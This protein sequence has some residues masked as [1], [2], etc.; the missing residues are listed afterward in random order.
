MGL[1]S[2]AIA[3][4]KASRAE[5]QKSHTQ[6][7]SH[8]PSPGHPAPRSR[9]PSPGPPAASSDNYGSAPPQYST[10]DPSSA[11]YGLVETTDEAYARHLIDKGEAIPWDQPHE[12]EYGD[13]EDEDDDEAYWELDEAAAREEAPGYE[14]SD[15]P[16]YEAK[17]GGS[18]AKE[19]KIDVHKLVKKFLSAHPAPSRAPPLHPLSCHVIIPQR[20]PHSKSRGFVRA[21]AP[22]L[23]DA[24][25]DQATFMDFLETFQK[26]SQVRHMNVP[27]SDIP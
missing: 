22:V 26:A 16:E 4:H 15:S 1:A 27:S 10:L 19:E 6:P 11:D 8:S 17:E 18:K 12:V 2:E 14:E 24:G 9:E 5:K 23:N 21:Y 20:R 13:V 7:D 3:A 25:I